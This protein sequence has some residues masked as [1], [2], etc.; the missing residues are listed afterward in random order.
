MKPNHTILSITL[1][2]I[3]A[4]ASSAQ[5]GDSVVSVD[6]ANYVAAFKVTETDLEP[7]KNAFD[8]VSPVPTGSTVEM[9]VQPPRLDTLVGKTIAMV[10][11]SFS[12]S[13]T[14]AV[15]RDMLIRDFGCTIYFMEEIGKGGSYNPINPR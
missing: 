14:H 9:I 1:F 15:M 3:I 13:V 6:G 7:E 2:S 4:A 12:A 11:G 8:I 5:V 10:G